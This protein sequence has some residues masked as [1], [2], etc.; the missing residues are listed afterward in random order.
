VADFYTDSHG[1][2]WGVLKQEKKMSCGPAC[3]AMTQ[4]YMSQISTGHMEAKARALSQKYKG[5]FTEAAGTQMSNLVQIL[6][7]EG[8]PCYDMVNAGPG[9]VWSYIYAYAKDNVPVIAHVEWSPVAAHFVMCVNVYKS[10]QHCIFLDP[11]YGM[12]EL[13]G[14]ELP[15][16]AA[17]SPKAAVGALSGWL[18]IMKP[19]N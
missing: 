11:A 12:T 4:I 9:G 8:Y 15:Y 18:I 3:V 16:Y 2:R 1:E 13:K 14:W 19:R 10:D 6:R 7:G 17:G 5:A